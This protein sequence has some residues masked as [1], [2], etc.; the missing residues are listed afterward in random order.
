MV[1]FCA[2]R[3]RILRPASV[4]ITPSRSPSTAS[5]TNLGRDLPSPWSG[6]ASA[7]GALYLVSVA[8]RF[9]VDIAA[10]RACIKRT[11][12]YPHGKSFTKPKENKDASEE[13]SRVVL[14]V[15]RRRIAQGRSRL[16]CPI[17]DDQS[18]ARRQSR[19]PGCGPPGPQEAL[20]GRP[21]G[22]RGRLHLGEHPAGLDRAAHG[23]AALPRGRDP[24]R[25]R[26]VPPRLPA[27]AEE[28][29]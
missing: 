27:D 1:T 25:Q 18:S 15:E 4:D 26:R 20:R 6:Y 28:G 24:H 7:N 16:S 5:P 10:D 21:Q 2:D 17:P 23:R 19:D 9:W 14:R 29:R 22:P 8:E 11:H 3:G 13:G 12:P